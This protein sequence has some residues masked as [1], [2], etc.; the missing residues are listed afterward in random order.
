MI[1]LMWTDVAQIVNDE[2]TASHWVLSLI[3]LTMYRQLNCA[4]NDVRP[5]WQND[6]VHDVNRDLGHEGP[7]QNDVALV[8]VKDV[9]DANWR[10]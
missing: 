9:N 6:S 3:L 8:S 7:N 1:A 5:S 4:D 2:M 10:H